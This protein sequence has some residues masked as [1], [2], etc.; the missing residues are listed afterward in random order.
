[1]KVQEVYIVKNSIFICLFCICIYLFTRKYNAFCLLNWCNNDISYLHAHTSLNEMASSLWCSGDV[2]KHKLCT[3]KNLCYLPRTENQFL[4]FVSN[5]TLMSGIKIK[6]DLKTLSLTSVIE[7]NGFSLKLVLINESNWD[8]VLMKNEEIFLI[9][10]FKPDNIMHVIHDDLLPLYATYNKI[11][12][13]DVHQCIS[14]YRLAFIDG[15]TPGPYYEWYLLLS[16]REP[17]FLEKEENIVCFEKVRFG[18]TR[19]S[20]WFQYGFRT[21]HGPVEPLIDSSLLKR[22]T[23]FVLK[24]FQINRT[25][26]HPELG[27]LFSRRFNR[28]INNEKFIVHETKKVY[29]HINPGNNLSIASL[30][31]S[32]NDSKT[33]ISLLQKSSVLL[34][35]HGS[36]MILS[37][38]LPPGAVIIELFPFGLQPQYVSP[39][40]A[41]CNVQGTTY[42][43][44]SWVNSKENNSLT[45][46]DFPPLLGGIS[47]L[48]E[49]MQE[50]IK[51]IKL[52]P[53]VKCCHNPV[54]LYRMYQDTI[55]D[56]SFISVLIE[57]FTTQKKFYKNIDHIASLQNYQYAKFYFPSLVTNVTCLFI[58]EGLN[59]SW[60]K[61]L[62]VNY[63]N[64]EYTLHLVTEEQSFIYKTNS[65][66]VVIKFNKQ[67]MLK[68][69]IWIHCTAGNSEG[70]DV[71]VEC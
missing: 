35:M 34:G 16:D 70:T 10:R 24:R 20:V 56:K 38:F 44:F 65:T 63:Y 37:I 42:H 26:I 36:A 39:I 71:Y 11:C 31:L 64:P 13:G 9:S 2:D 23:D 51:I 52:V 60:N 66:Y 58:N 47:Y 15:I 45:H 59:I 68:I 49:K 62:N 43:Y 30:D 21:V 54:Y 18:L 12:E 17:I 7:H 53:P 4:F 48:P 8:G 32:A 57:A 69:Q 40:R 1:M 28:K 33:T 41:M 50:N 27:V 46:E 25:K 55:I 19:E 3:V 67:N 5:E 14:K 22:F 6:E 61:P 29:E